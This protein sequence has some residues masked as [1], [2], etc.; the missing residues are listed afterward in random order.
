MLQSIFS[1]L[2]ST[3]YVRSV[4]FMSLIHKNIENKCI[5]R[6]ITLV[7]DDASSIR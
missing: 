2:T 7:T 6:F 3:V 1:Q 4:R 5:I